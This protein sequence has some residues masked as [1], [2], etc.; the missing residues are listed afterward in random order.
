MSLLDRFKNY[1]DNLAPNK[2][3]KIEEVTPRKEKKGV[4]CGKVAVNIMKRL[5]GE[6][7]MKRIEGK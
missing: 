6:N 2:K 4:K 1:T 5:G 3:Q 7:G